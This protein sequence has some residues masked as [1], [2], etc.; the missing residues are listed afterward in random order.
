MHSVN[1]L[2]L[3]N[4]TFWQHATDTTQPHWATSHFDTW[5]KCTLSCRLVALQHIPCLHSTFDGYGASLQHQPLPEMERHHIRDCT[6]RAPRSVR[7]YW[8]TFVCHLYGRLLQKI[9]FLWSLNSNT[10]GRMQGLSYCPRSKIPERLTAQSW[11]AKCSIN[12]TNWCL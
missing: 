10:L 3:S 12:N 8:A 5:V 4:T 6:M 11:P 9:T 7:K 1:K 2:V